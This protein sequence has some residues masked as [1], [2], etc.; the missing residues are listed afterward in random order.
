M[1]EVYSLNRARRRSEAPAFDFPASLKIFAETFGTGLP[2]TFDRFYLKRSRRGTVVYIQNGALTIG[3]S[4]ITG[5][6]PKTFKDARKWV[7]A[8]AERQ[9]WSMTEVTRDEAFGINRT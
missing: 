2:K 5:I 6:Y 8:V 3:L 7:A 1:A 9:N 4:P